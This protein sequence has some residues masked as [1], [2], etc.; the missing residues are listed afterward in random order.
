LIAGAWLDGHRRG[1]KIDN[2]VQVAHNVVMG[3]GCI[4]VG[5][6]GI[7]GST[8]LGNFVTLAG[9]WSRW[10]FEDWSSGTVA[11]QS[12][13]I[14]RHTRWHK[15]AWLTSAPDKEAKRQYIAVRRLPVAAPS[16]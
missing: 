1:T 10:A 11:A 3:E 9:S 15:M 5:Q 13:V 12:G 14:E 2:L 4:I 8:K 7:A 6:A 16:G